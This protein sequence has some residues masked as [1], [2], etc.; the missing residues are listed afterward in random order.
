MLASAEGQQHARPDQRDGYRVGHFLSPQRLD[1][2]S[3]FVV[4]AI[5]VMVDRHHPAVVGVERG[6]QIVDRGAALPTSS[7]R[8]YSRQRSSPRPRLA[9][10]HVE[11]D[12]RRD[13]GDE[14]ELPS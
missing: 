3:E 5:E 14:R 11:V 12:P 4:L 2:A 9:L 6:A 10:L 1:L 8:S 7:I 13:I